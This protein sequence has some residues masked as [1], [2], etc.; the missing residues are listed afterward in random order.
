MGVASLVLGIVSVI[1][2]FIPLCGTW[3]II[4]A[5]VGLV[6][7]IIDWSKK[8]KAN[9]PKGKAIAGTICSGVAIIVI[10]TWWMLFGAAAGIA[11]N[12]LQSVDWN[13]ALTS[14]NAAL[15]Q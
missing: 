7:G 14:L 13:E 8:Q 5:I 15:E 3:A 6:L 10:V 4:P 2:G 9:E 1:V 12:E 11:S